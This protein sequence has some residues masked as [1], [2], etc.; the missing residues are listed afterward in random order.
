MGIASCFIVI[1]LTAQHSE[2]PWDI[3]MQFSS[4]TQYNIIHNKSLHPVNAPDDTV[5]IVVDNQGIWTVLTES[6]VTVGG[7]R[8]NSEI[9]K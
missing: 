6:R 5:I 3:F 1:V 9:E 2:S 8:S 7:E 4:V